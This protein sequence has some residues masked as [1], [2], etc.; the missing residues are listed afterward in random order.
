[1]STFK[2][3]FQAPHLF[4][5]LF[6]FLTLQPLFAEKYEG[7]WNS[8]VEAG[9]HV[10][11][12]Q[13]GGGMDGVFDVELSINSNQ[14]YEPCIVWAH[15]PGDGIY[16]I[17]ATEL[18]FS[19]RDAHSGVWSTPVRITDNDFEEENVQFVV[20]QYTPEIFHVFYTASKDRK[21]V[22]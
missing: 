17:Q 19:K 5:F 4:L 15:T 11:D 8:F 13:G 9:P 20:T 21:S 10:T 16:T 22:V 1:M 18:Y 14:I 2:N 12:I 3:V 6:V 7:L